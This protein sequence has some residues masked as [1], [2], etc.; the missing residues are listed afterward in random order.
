M[1]DNKKMLCLDIYFIASKVNENFGKPHLVYLKAWITYL[2]K[3]LSKS[4][5][6]SISKQKKN[7]SLLVL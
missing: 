5:D 4:D 3:E 7:L 6:K 1:P 2:V